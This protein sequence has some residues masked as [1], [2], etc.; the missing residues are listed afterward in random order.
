MRWARFHP[1]KGKYHA[2]PQAGDKC[3]SG[4]IIPGGCTSAI[5]MCGKSIPIA[6][7]KMPPGHENHPRTSKDMCG[8]C[9]KKI[10]K[11]YPPE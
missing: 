4:R 11:L 5:T 2:Y 7:H 3:D 1:L 8:L 10:N 6:P 9:V